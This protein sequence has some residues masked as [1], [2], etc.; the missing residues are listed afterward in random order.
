MKD[1]I[2]KIRDDKT[3]EEAVKIYELATRPPKSGIPPAK[4]EVIEFCVDWAKSHGE[5]IDW[6]IMKAEE[7]FDFYTG[8]MSL[9]NARTWKDGNGSTVKNWKLKL[10]NCWLKSR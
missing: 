10:Q 4:Q 8:N 5:D 9:M 2:I 7:A 1:L 6:C 3:L